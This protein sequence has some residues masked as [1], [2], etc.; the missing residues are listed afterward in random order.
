MKT[1][2]ITSSGAW[3]LS[4]F[5]FAI[6]TD[7]VSGDTSTFQAFHF[8]VSTFLILIGLFEFL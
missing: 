5:G 2:F 8:P 6:A 7:Q 3:K 4:G 1:V